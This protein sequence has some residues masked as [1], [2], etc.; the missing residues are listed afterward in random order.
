MLYGRV[1]I[2]YTAVYYTQ[3][4]LFALQIPRYTGVS[5]GRYNNNNDNAYAIE[6]SMYYCLDR[7]GY[8]YI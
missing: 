1:P 5:N 6:T 7:S 2:A 8:I 3:V 4:R